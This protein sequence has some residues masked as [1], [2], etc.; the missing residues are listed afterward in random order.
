MDAFK[1][2]VAW[3]AQVP[4]I[5]SGGYHTCGLTSTGAAYCW[6]RNDYGQLGDGTTTNRTSPVPVAGGLTFQALA[7]GGYHTCGLTASGAAY[8]WGSN[9]YGQLGDGMQTDRGSP[10]A[11]A[12]GL[13]F[14][15]LSAG[16]YHT[17][18]LTASG[19]AYCWGN[20]SVGQLGDGTTNSRSRP[21]AVAGG[22]TLR[23]LSAGSDHTCGLTASGAAYCWGYNSYGQL[24]D[25]STT[26]RTSPVAVA[27][28]L[29]FQALSAGDYHTCGLTSTGAAYCW[30]N[31]AYGQL[32]DGTTT[33][34]SSPV[35]VAGGLTLRA[36]SAGSA[37]TCGLTA[38]GAAYCW[39]LNGDGQLG[40]GTTTSRSSPVAVAGGLTFQALS[41]RF[42]TCGLTP[43]GAA[44]CWGNNAYGQLGDGTTSNR[45]T[46]VAVLSFSPPA[47]PSNL[48]ASAVS[49]AQI[50][51][52]WT[53]NST[54]EDG[55]RIERCSG[56]G[57]TS[58]AQV[59]TVGANATTYSDT[60]LAAGT[61]YSYRVRAYNAAGNSGYSNVAGAWTVATLQNGVAVTGLA[62]STGG[63]KYFALTV[64][65]N[66]SWLEIT[67]E[68]GSGDVDIYVRRAGL[69]TTGTYACAG[70]AS[71]P[72]E[73]CWLS[74]PQDGQW[75]VML[76]GNSSYEGVT[77]TARAW[78]TVWSDDFESYAAG[79]W[80][81]PNW[82]NS[83]NTDG[84]ITTSYYV[85]PSKS[86]RLY[87]VVGEFWGALAHRSLG[88]SAPFIA[89]CHVRNG[90]ETI[91]SS[92]HQARA[93][94]D[95]HVGP[96]WTTGPRHLMSFHKDGYMYGP[97]GE[98][99]GPYEVN[100]WYPV[101][102]KYEYP[103]A[104]QVR[105]SIWVNNQ[106]RVVSTLT[107]ASY[108]SQLAYLGVTAQAGTVWYDNCRVSR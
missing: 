16:D 22:L 92:G 28:G 55:F 14:Q 20:N 12:G 59:A 86:L 33:S 56:S 80:P 15:A 90:S 24:G 73:E 5:N 72:S 49:S 34:R 18:G 26:N 32:G 88:T 52:S 93:D 94:F 44:Y 40:D 48:A 74:D 99:L 100:T 53:D 1:L 6:G 57:C 37:H 35:A 101:R 77:L 102:L 50:N 91:P 108:E 63:R 62:D 2:V 97:L 43:S 103:V 106:R 27:G 98:N 84:S 89:E 61:A 36:L 75:Y 107:P 45:T 3:F 38:S 46:P 67:T 104:G 66:A 23:A 42:H 96:S 79:S 78:T 21:V 82:A 10:V 17:C 95:L 51:L 70:Q 30:G 81:S 13:T 64:P 11:V 68:G 25:G 87:G 9:Q 19:A 83:G 4:R 29:T 8:C 69:P 31:N 76:H 7:A 58:F 54:T 71:G 105:V 65:T 41:A 60:G 39:G 85:S 47:A